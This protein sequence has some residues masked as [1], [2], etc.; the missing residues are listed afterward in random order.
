[1]GHYHPLRC[2]HHQYIQHML[3]HMAYGARISS[4]YLTDLKSSSMAR[5][6]IIATTRRDYSPNQNCI[7]SVTV[8]FNCVVFVASSELC[9]NINTLRLSLSKANRDCY[10]ESWEVH[11]CQVQVTC[12]LAQ[13]ERM[14]FWHWLRGRHAECSLAKSSWLWRRLCTAIADINNSCCITI[15]W[16]GF[17]AVVS[18][19]FWRESHRKRFCAVVLTHGWPITG[20]LDTESYDFN[21][22]HSL[23][24]IYILE[25]YMA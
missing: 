17:A 2:I 8:S 25:P 24:T 5:M 23:R 12:Y 11:S 14:I 16:N 15:I 21:G 3:K 9:Y 1:M 19:P 18:P 10:V 4:W 6:Q 20:L 22:P 13:R 7:S